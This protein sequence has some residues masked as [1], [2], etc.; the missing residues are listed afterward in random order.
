MW[1][2]IAEKFSVCCSANASFVMKEEESEFVQ[3]VLRKGLRTT[4]I[5]HTFVSRIIRK[6]NNTHR[7]RNRTMTTIVDKELGKIIIEPKR[8]MK[9]VVARRRDDGIHLSIPVS[10]TLIEAQQ[11][12]N[13]MRKKLIKLNAR[14]FPEFDIRDGISSPFL[15][16]VVEEQP[17]I[18]SAA[19]RRQG[20]RFVIMLPHGWKS[21]NKPH[22]TLIK[23]VITN[24][25]KLRAQ[26]VLLPLTRDLASKHGF[27][28]HNVRISKSK[29]R[30][31]S[32]SKTNNIN[33]SCHLMLMS[34][35]FVEYV[36]LHELMHT[37]HF[38]HSPAFWQQLS[39]VCGFDAKTFRKH[40]ELPASYQWLIR[41]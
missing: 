18:E 13:Q 26:E 6:A 16:I 19:V 35:K 37:K 2:L 14:P 7:I 8:R 3:L 34:Q 20:N 15:D 31:G 28:I 1:R 39:K 41:E 12:I 17:Q 27:T 33:L 10:M 9:N 25:L 36:I 22:P 4:A 11:I 40:E 38:D 5:F 23:P 30:W 21:E 29:T 32:C 24:I